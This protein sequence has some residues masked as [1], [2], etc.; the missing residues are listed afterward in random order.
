MLG[1]LAFIYCH[2]FLLLPYIFY[3]LGE[4]LFFFFNEN[5]L[6]KYFWKKIKNKSELKLS[7]TKSI[8]SEILS[9][10]SVKE[11]IWGRIETV[12]K[13]YCYELYI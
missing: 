13:E 6:R 1:N 3:H 12:Y 8:E 9:D 7:E 4:I 2:V 5:V 10:N 11:K